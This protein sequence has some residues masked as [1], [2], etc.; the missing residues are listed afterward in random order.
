MPD[1]RG[2][3]GP[4]DDLRSVV[5]EDGMEDVIQLPHA[6]TAAQRIVMGADPIE[7]LNQVLTELLREGLIRVYRGVDAKLDEPLPEAQALDLLKDPYWYS[8]HLPDDDPDT[9]LTY[10]NVENIRPEFR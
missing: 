5:L 9:R 6:A 3:V 8:F 1:E 7:A 4:D 10:I 2:R